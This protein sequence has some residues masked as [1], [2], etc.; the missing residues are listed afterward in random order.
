MKYKIKLISIISILC[1]L[2][3]AYATGCKVCY[4]T[5]N[6]PVEDITQILVLE[7]PNGEILFEIDEK[8]YEECVDDILNLEATLYYGPPA[9]FGG[10]AFKIVFSNGEYDIITNWEPQHWV[11]NEQGEVL[12]NAFSRLHFN[13]EQF[14]QLIEKWSNYKV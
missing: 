9:D 3:C 14:N 1:C 10:K 12:I 11:L 6:H 4:W 8:Y 13:D 5:I 2:V 7:S